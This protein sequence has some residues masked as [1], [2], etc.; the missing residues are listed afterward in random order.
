MLTKCFDGSLAVRKKRPVAKLCQGESAPCGGPSAHVLHASLNADLGLEQGR[1]S[2]THSGH[3]EPHWTLCDD[4]CVHKYEVRIAPVNAILLHNSFVRIDDGKGTTR[5]IAGSNGWAVDYG[6]G[7]IGGD[8]PGGVQDFS[9]SGRNHNPRICGSRRLTSPAYFCCGA[10]TSKREHLIFHPGFCE[11]SAPGFGEEANS[12]ASGND[13]GWP[14]EAEI[15]DFG[16]KL[17]RGTG[18]LRV[19]GWSAEDFEHV[20]VT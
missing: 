17:L 15:A 2:I 13:D 1:E 14:I 12:A 9:A 16:T 7:E 3:Q 4:R 18:P 19:A 6:K 11:G 20:S 8:G 5:S 10:F